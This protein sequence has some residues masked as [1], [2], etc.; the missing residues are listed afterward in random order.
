M[1]RGGG[2][3]DRPRGARPRHRAG[4]DSG[5]RPSSMHRRAPRRRA[6]HTIIRRP[7]A[8]VTRC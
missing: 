2:H 5:R 6:A 8:A 4:V 7:S 3:P 1:D